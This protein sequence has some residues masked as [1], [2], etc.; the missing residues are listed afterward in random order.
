MPECSGD[1]V[2]MGNIFEYWVNC[3]IF[4]A[5]GA[6]MTHSSFLHLHLLTGINLCEFTVIK[7]HKP[8]I[9]I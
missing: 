5:S 8:L 3:V 6:K 1:Y 2:L 7:L 9:T 4:A